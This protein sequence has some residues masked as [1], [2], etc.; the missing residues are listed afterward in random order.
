MYLMTVGLFYAVTLLAGLTGVITN[1]VTTRAGRGVRS[2]WGM[3]YYTDFASLGLF[4]LI[5]VWVA[6]H[7]LPDW[8][9]L[10]L[11]AGFAFL[12]A[13][14]AHSN[15]STLCV[16]LMFCAIL[17]HG[18]ERRII[19]RKPGLGWMKKGPELFALFSF[20]LLA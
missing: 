18:F 1:Y 17:W 5:A 11:C 7:K 19:D 20:P 8:T 4:I 14:I 6:C 12:S 16:G 10:L 3:S 9:M 2:A 13:H 15:T